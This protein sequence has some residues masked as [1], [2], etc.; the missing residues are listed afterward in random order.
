MSVLQ[1]VRR[2]LPA[3]ANH[4]RNT[5]Q[6]RI[7]TIRIQNGYGGVAER[8]MAPVLKTGG[9]QALAGSNPA[10]SDAA[11]KGPIPW[12][13]SRRQDETGRLHRLPEAAIPEVHATTQHEQGSEA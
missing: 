7:T 10:P 6:D 3:S 13:L 1:Y 5:N 11:A 8:L 12:L 2:G 9:A 4:W